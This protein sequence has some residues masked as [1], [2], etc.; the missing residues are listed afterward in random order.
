MITTRLITL[1]CIASVSVLGLRAQKTDSIPHLQLRETMVSTARNSSFNYGEYSF[2]PKQLILPASLFTFGALGTTLRPYK[3]FNE[4]VRDKISDLRGNHKTK[5]DNYIQ[6]LPTATHLLLGLTRVRHKN[7][8]VQ[9]LSVDATSA[10]SLTVLTNVMKSTF[11][12]KRPD[13]NSKNSFPSG[14][15]ATAFM[16]AELMRIEYGPYWGIGGYSVATAVG[17]LRIY[18][19]R[20]WVNDVIAGAGI[21]ILSARIGYWMLPFYNKWFFGKVSERHDSDRAISFTALPSFDYGNSSFTINCM[22]EF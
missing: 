7:S 3:D 16:G 19:E 15:T 13:S 20:H 21:G 6:Y 18:N 1:L 9:R 4:K 22:L 10:I 2:R 14:H 11:R 17:L 8:F 12:E 5:V